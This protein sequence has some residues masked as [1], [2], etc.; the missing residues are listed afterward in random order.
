MS[1]EPTTATLRRYEPSSTLPSDRPQRPEQ[2]CAACATP[3]DPLRAPCALAYDDGVKLLC[4]E[5]CREQYRSGQR[6]RRPAHALASA[7][8]SASVPPGPLARAAVSEDVLRASLPANDVVRPHKEAARRPKQAPTLVSEPPAAA[9]AAR[10][11]AAWLWVG[12]ATLGTAAAL[13]GFAGQEMALTTA[14]L[15]MVG[16]IAGLRLSWPSARDVSV[17]GWLLGPL[18]VIGTIV[19][20]YLAAQSGPLGYEHAFGGVLAAA[21]LLA[22]SVLDAHAGK[23]VASALAGL[24]SAL[25]DQVQVPVRGLGEQDAVSEPMQATKIRVGEEVV[26][27]SGERLGVDGVVQAGQAE[28]IPYPGAGLQVRRG[29]GDAV[30]AGAQ[31]VSGALRV[32]ASR[33]GDDRALSRVARAG[34]P[35]QRVPAR[36]A[37]L[38]ARAL[39]FL[40]LLSFGLG[41]GLCVAHHLRDAPLPLAAASTLWFVTPLLA[42]RRAAQWPLESAAIAAC[43]RGILFQS[44]RALDLAGH[45][46]ALAMAPHRVL[47][48]GKPEVLDMMTFGDDKP[49]ELLA[50]AAGAELLSGAHPIGLAIAAFA[51]KR[52]VAPSDMRR[53]LAVSGRGLIGTGPD[54]EDIVI[55]SRRLLLD[56]GVSVA[57]ADAYAVRA[58]TAGRTAVFMAV[59]GRVKAVFALHDDLRP[60][61]R[62]AVQRLFDLGLEVVL[63]TGDQRG[64]VEQ[65]AAGFDIAHIKCELLPEERAEEVRSLRDAGGPVAVIGYP[66]DDAAAL[67]AADVAIALGAAGTGTGDN[68]IALLSEDLRDAAAALWIARAA[69][70]SA[71]RSLRVSLAAFCAVAGAAVAG[72]ITPGLAAMFALLIDFHGLRTG[73]RF[74]HRVALRFGSSS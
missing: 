71:L 68:A 70:A 49:K 43:S 59:S 33:V 35:E 66:A 26:V 12:A 37:Y 58:E 17:V 6:V 60:G 34:R 45:V 5:A 67:A 42:L 23:P 31:L 69:R 20:T 8:V 3:V 19:A 24:S 63:L 22:R 10:V 54:G 4:S 9:R 40:A 48:E 15:S 52:G 62:A 21:A 53:A 18:G 11:T 36:F 29:P 28:L 1:L 46:A 50:L 7:K 30:L 74:L 27:R 64:P 14:S 51:D 39:P 16:A 38:T 65:L 73:T 13:A 44:G 72:L 25:P 47:T 32:L 55:G 57:T 41:V 61:A 56:Q 2:P